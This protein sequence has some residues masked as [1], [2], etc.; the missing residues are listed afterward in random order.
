MTGYKGPRFWFRYLEIVT[1][2]RKFAKG[3]DV[4]EI[5]AGTLELSSFLAE[6][7]NVTALDLSKDLN[8][9]HEELPQSLKKNI[10]CVE[11]DFLEHDFKNQKFDIIIAMEVLE[12]ITNP[13]L[14]LEKMKSLLKKN[15]LVVISVPAHMSLWS[16]HDVAVGH[17]KRYEKKDMEDVSKIF[18]NGNFVISAYGWP[19][20]NLLRH[21]RIFTSDF[22]YKNA[23][24]LSSKDRSVNSGKRI[25][26]LNIFRFIVNKYT[27]Y[28]FWIISK[29]F[30]KTD[31]SEGYI[32]FQEFR[33]DESSI[34]IQ[35]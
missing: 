8:N 28:P 11:A 22:L 16:K 13:K 18:N 25:K 10:A 3:K 1:Y 34:H 33:E 20:I 4:L 19:W 2:L 12:H 5:G 14:F 27:I 29:L 6:N 35:E 23:K 30:V 21:L 15:S 7:N 9:G 17:V 24:N 31:L 26:K 32:L